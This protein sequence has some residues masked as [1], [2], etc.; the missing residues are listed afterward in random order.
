MAPAP[1]LRILL[2]QD[3]PGL[4]V[5]RSLE[6]D[7]VVE[8][9]TVES[10]SEWLLRII[11]AHIEFDR[12]HGRPPLSAFPQ[13]P[14]RYW[15]AFVDATILRTV[16]CGRDGSVTD[17]ARVI[18]IALT[19]NRPPAI[20]PGQKPGGHQAPSTGASTPASSSSLRVN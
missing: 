10:A 14:R 7:I 20:P 4:W 3:L 16:S 15:N 17:P 1:W 6:H 12:R 11:L 2:Y 9:T 19:H 5:A 18:L 13:A 8:G